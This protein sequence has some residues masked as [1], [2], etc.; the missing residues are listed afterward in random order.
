MTDRGPWSV[1]GIDQRARAVARDAARMEG[2]TLGEYLN[3]LILNDTDDDIRHNEVRPSGEYGAVS[4]LDHLTRRVEAVE[5]RST[6]AITGIDQS[7]MGLVA[8]LQKAEDNNTVIAGHVD[9]FIEELRETHAALSD[10]VRRLED[11]DSGE[12]NLDALRSLEEALGKLATHVYEEGEQAQME[13]DAIKGRVEAGFVDLTDRMEQVETRVESTLTQAAKRVEEAVEQAELRAQGATREL[14]EQ[15]EGRL[16]RVEDDVQGALGSMEQTML[17]IQERLNRAESTTDA[18]L[19]GLESTFVALDDKVSAI[20]DVAGPEATARLKAELEERFQGL[21]DELKAEIESS[22][23]AMAREIE[24]AGVSD[25]RSEVCDLRTDLEG[26]RGEATASEA[27]AASAFA[28]IG[29]QVSGISDTFHARL[30]AVEAREAGVESG[31]IDRVSDEVGKLAE[32]LEARVTESETASAR[33]IEQIGEQVS[34]VAQRL[35][36][37]QDE[38]FGRLSAH[39]EETRTAQETRL[40]EALANMSDRFGKIHAE[41]T[42]EKLSPVQDAI[43]SLASRLEVLEGETDAPAF[44]PGLPERISPDAPAAAVA[45]SAENDSAVDDDADMLAAFSAAVQTVETDV[46][47]AEAKV[48][49]GA[50][51]GFT[52]GLPEWAV[53]PQTESD[54]DYTPGLPVETIEPRGK[55]V[56]DT[57]PLAALGKWDSPLDDHGGDEVRE[58]DVFD[59]EVSEAQAS[60]TLSPPAHLD[61][62]LD[63]P[64]NTLGET[65]TNDGVSEVNSVLEVVEDATADDALEE[66]IDA[67]D[68]IARARMAAIA[69]AQ[70]ASGEAET[71]SGKSMGRV[72]LYAAASMI[73]LATAGTTGYL[74]LRGKQAPAGPTMAAVPAQAAGGSGGAASTPVS[75][76]GDAAAGLSAMAVSVGLNADG[77][78]LGEAEATPIEDVD[79][80][81]TGQ[82]QEPTRAAVE[83]APTPAPVS[84]ATP[85]AAPEPQPVALP[86]R[87]AF[88]PIPPA[89]TLASA[90]ESGDRIASYELGVQRLNDADYSEGARLVQ[91]SARNGL[92]MAQYRLSKLHE[93]GL[94]VPR[95]LAAARRWTERAANGGNVRAMHDLAVF[96]ADGEG[97]DQSYAKSVEWFR[98]AAEYGVLDSQYNLAVLYEQGLG[99]TEDVSEALFWFSIAAEN[100]DPGAGDQVR[101]LLTRVDADTAR[102]IRARVQAWRG[103]RPNGPANGEFGRQPWQGG[104]LERVR[105]V[106]TALNALGYAV[107]TPDGVIGPATRDAIRSYQRDAGIPDTGT[108]SNAFIES[109][110]SKAAGAVT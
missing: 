26:M 15:T 77:E 103:A 4:T 8:R 14:A 29:E 37:R 30:E 41:T 71:K 97:G 10:K 74:Y 11:D 32:R 70:G 34:T 90:A 27:R 49:V 52:P 7:V 98:K 63:M 76:S 93:K 9:T 101:A 91:E 18:A 94:G 35:Q 21:A 78:A 80:I 88:D 25:I 45:E 47:Q 102:T 53:S 83:V 66:D 109:L 46:D 48:A 108:L 59:T 51:E 17:R 106:Q 2:V 61:L 23:A 75:A 87:A 104:G 55:S 84:Q 86:Q 13:S 20:S 60:A 1:K 64:R 62:D 6:L 24:D 54:E 92:P 57:D 85:E 73:V 5:A 38:A 36:G 50:E 68:Y 65:Y 100:G 28:A 82:L 33:A 44:T 58:S 12:R 31:A 96:F 105:A 39:V 22:R 3:N 43:A 81:A 40:S 95:D 42:A 72:P 56:A 79:A 107:G 19:K 69:A 89:L 110:N 67:S 99:I 16:S